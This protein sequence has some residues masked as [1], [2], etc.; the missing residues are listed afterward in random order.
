MTR[1]IEITGTNPVIYSDFPDPDIIR[2]GDT[3]YMA[4][5]TMHFMP[6]CDILRSYDLVNWEL[7]PQAYDVLDD[8]PRHYLAGDKN[9]YGEGMWAPTFRYHKGKFYIAFTANDTHKTYLLT[10]ENPEGPWKKSTIEGWYYDS[11]LFFDDDDRVYIVHGQKELHL[12]Q[13]KADLTGPE[14]GGLSRVV[15]ADREDANLGYEG[16][17]MYKRNGKY[18]I[19]TCHMRKGEKKTEDCFVSDS[20]TGKFEGKCIIDDDMGY[21]GLGVAQGGMVDTPEGDWY[22]FMFQ[23]RGA[24]GRAPMVMPMHFEDDFPVIGDHGKVPS[25][26]TVTSTRPDYIYEPVNGDDDFHYEAGMDGKV[27]LKRFWEFNHQPMNALWSVTERPGYFRM[28]SG[29]IAPTIFQ[30]YNL[31]TQRTVGPSC[32]AEVTVDGSQLKEGDVAGIC[33]FISSCGLIGLT[34]EAEKY[35]LVMLGRQA[36]NETIF[37]DF[38]YTAPAVEYGRLEVSNPVVRLRAEADFEDMT[39]RACFYYES[40]EHWKKLGTDQ[41]MYFK[42]DLFTGCRFGLFYYSTKEIGGMADFAKFYFYFNKNKK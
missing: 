26:V 38:D 10:S 19:F 5:T 35:Y 16:S 2:V 24:L 12:T 21:H 11:S 1:T 4:S 3:Y 32:A 34:K 30:S 9:I 8:T 40:G 22:I 39:D 7:L 29:K 41:R 31:L 25:E 14:P 6:G 28:R 20:L 27:T 36:K 37:G 18:Y 23:D 33:T 15:A 42:M 17:H 13:L